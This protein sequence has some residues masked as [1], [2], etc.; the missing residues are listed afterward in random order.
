MSKIRGAARHLRAH[1]VGYVA[2]FVALGG[3][4]AY[5]AGALPKGSVGVRQL[6]PSA[7]TSPKV[8]DGS[9]RAS[10]FAAGQLP[11]GE[12]GP[13]GQTG[14]TGERGATGPQGERGPSG[15]SVFDGPPPSGTALS[16]RFE[17]GLPVA[18]GKRAE[19][20]V[21]FP[22]PLAA[23]QPTGVGFAPSAG[24][25]PGVTDPAC[26][27]SGEAPTAPA[28]KVCIYSL[29]SSGSGDYE[30]F[31]LGRRGFSFS[32]LATGGNPDFV[33]FRGAWA[34]TAP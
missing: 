15:Y 9:L 28:G 17:L 4:S 33:D 22:V 20:G 11:R 34:Y 1:A 30:T 13:A 32:M 29:G 16:G 12:R 25:G 24:A 27:G 2:L 10:D 14:P 21:S 31:N 7:V 5:A 6:K 19:W 26:T 3:T 18:T 23:G 8:K